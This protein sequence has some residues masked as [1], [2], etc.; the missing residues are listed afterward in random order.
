MDPRKQDIH[1]FNTRFQNLLNLVLE[2]NPHF[3]FDQV[4]FTWIQA[5]PEEFVDLHTKFNKNNLDEKWKKVNNA[6]H[7]FIQTIEEMRECNINLKSSSTNTDKGDK[8]LTIKLCKAI[9]SNY[10][11]DFPTDYPDNAKLYNKIKELVD[12]GTSK[13][14]IEK[15][16]KEHYGF[17]S[18][19]LCRIKPYKIGYHQD[20]KCP[21]LKQLFKPYSPLNILPTPCT[22]DCSPL[23]S[24]SFSSKKTSHAEQPFQQTNHTYKMC[25][26]TFFRKRL[27]NT[28]KYNSN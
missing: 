15:K 9:P 7:L 22:T 1:S 12:G 10:R 24:T 20:D 18:C 5:L 2:T 25:Y 28:V 17:K 4:K 11:G 23:A 16:F 19:W 8:P 27:K 3:T 6:A 13:L 26:D 21:L 14:D